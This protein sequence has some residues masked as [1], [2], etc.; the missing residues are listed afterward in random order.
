MNTRRKFLSECTM[1]LAALALLP[2]ATIGWSATAAG[3]AE[4]PDPLNHEAL[5]GQ[6]N[7]LFR[8]HLSSG[9]VVELKLLKAPLAPPTSALPGRRPPGDAGYE[10]FSLIFSGSKDALL[11]SAIHQFEHNQLGRFEMHI[12]QIGA[13]DASSVRYE[14]VFNQPATTA[15]GR[16]TSTW[17]I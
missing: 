8:V 7:T 11:A 6:I 16:D 2:T 17:R 15:S 12:G 14:A 1:S 5:A 9:R 10:K 4:S 3:S 13:P